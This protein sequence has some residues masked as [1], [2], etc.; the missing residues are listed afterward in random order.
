MQP[1]VGCSIANS[2]KD[3]CDER[4]PIGRDDDGE[5]QEIVALYL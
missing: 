3:A 1:P 5:Y 2:S 4:S